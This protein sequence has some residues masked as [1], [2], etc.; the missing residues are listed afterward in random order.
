MSSWSVSGRLSGTGGITAV[1]V[2][3]SLKQLNFWRVS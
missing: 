1:H 3:C 2:T